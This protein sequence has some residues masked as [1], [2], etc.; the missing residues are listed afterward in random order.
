MRWTPILFDVAIVI[1][2]WAAVFKLQRQLSARVAAN[3]LP[4]AVRGCHLDRAALICATTGFTFFIVWLI[5]DAVGPHWLHALSRPAAVILIAIGAA[6][7]GCAAWIR[8]R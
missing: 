8:A 6:L 5:T 7:S 1:A 4:R 2:V 3:P